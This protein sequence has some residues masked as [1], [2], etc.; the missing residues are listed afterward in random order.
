MVAMILSNTAVL[1]TFLLIQKSN[2]YW[3]L[4]P[5]PIQR[6]W[7][8]ITSKGHFAKWQPHNSNPRRKRISKQQENDGTAFGSDALD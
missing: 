7:W 5:V 8:A 3:V 6:F 2:C 1:L 4:A